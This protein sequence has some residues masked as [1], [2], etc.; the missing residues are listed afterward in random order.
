MFRCDA[1]VT[2]TCLTWHIS[3][4]LDR[5]LHIA[6]NRVRRIQAHSGILARNSFPCPQNPPRFTPPGGSTPPPGTS[7]FG[8]SRLRSL[9]SDS[10]SISGY[11]P[12][13]ERNPP[14]NRRVS[15]WK[16]V[17]LKNGRWRYCKPAVAKNGKIK[18][19]WVIVKGKHQRHL[20]GTF[21]LHRY[22]RNI[23]RRFGESSDPKRRRRSTPPSP[24]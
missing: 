10:P 16:Y 2:G 14:M 1:V 17:R 9:R 13:A 7:T 11:V 4:V 5:N 6:E 23:T 18:A 3:H 21:Y 24:R 12:R 15:V 8:V 19:D 22:D 20:E